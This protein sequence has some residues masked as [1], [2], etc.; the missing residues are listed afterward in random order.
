MISRLMLSLRK[1]ADSQRNGL[2][3]GDTL[4]SSKSF[5]SARFFRSRKGKGSNGEDVEIPLST[6]PGSSS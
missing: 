5:Q 4:A 6:Y 3:F 1:A 2:V